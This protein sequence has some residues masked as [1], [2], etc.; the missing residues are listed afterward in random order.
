MRLFYCPKCDM[1]QL[2][3]YNP[4]RKQETINNMRDGY[5][6]PIRHYLC[7][8]GNYLAGSMDVTDWGDG[9]ISYAKKLIADYN[10]DGMFY[11][12]G[13]YE[14]AKEAYRRRHEM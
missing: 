13:L 1:Q 12:D 11:E 6:R 9:G 4:Y 8:C 14:K 3:N 2:L 10:K 5:G 7:E